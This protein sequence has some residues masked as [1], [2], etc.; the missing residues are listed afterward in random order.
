MLSLAKDAR[1]DDR[2]SLFEDKRGACCTPTPVETQQLGLGRVHEPDLPS[3]V[4][5]REEYLYSARTRKLVS[6]AR[7]NTSSRASASVNRQVADL[8]VGLPAGSGDGGERG[9]SARLV[10]GQ[11][12]L[13]SQA[14]FFIRRSF[15]CGGATPLSVIGTVSV[16]E[17]ARPGEIIRALVG[18]GVATLTSP[19]APA[20]RPRSAELAA[21]GSAP[22]SWVSMYAV[23]KIRPLLQALESLTATRCSMDRVTE[24][25]PTDPVEPP[26]ENLRLALAQ[27]DAGSPGQARRVA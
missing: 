2:L 15:R 9:W 7:I 27:G 10:D 24:E 26:P 22:A 1:H 8:V 5:L 6:Q 21:C 19:Q 11:L 23:A 14:L 3:G 16:K 4:H 18:P 17:N 25:R 12:R 13:W 20:T